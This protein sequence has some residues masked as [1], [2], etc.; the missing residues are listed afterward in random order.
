[1]GGIRGRGEGGVLTNHSSPTR[2]T[3]L[4]RSG[5]QFAHASSTLFE[6][7]QSIV[8]QRSETTEN[9]RSLPSCV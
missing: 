7:F 6:Q 4:F 9:E 2:F 5:N 1:M 8:A 3:D